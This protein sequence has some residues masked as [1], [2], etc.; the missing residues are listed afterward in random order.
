MKAEGY[1]SCDFLYPGMQSFKIIIK[2]LVHFSKAT[3]IRCPAN[4]EETFVSI[5]E[6]F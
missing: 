5:D 6:L 4:Q 1:N 3:V 2:P